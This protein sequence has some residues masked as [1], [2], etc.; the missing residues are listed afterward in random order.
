MAEPESN[1]PKTEEQEP[2]HKKQSFASFVS[3]HKW[4]SFSYLVLFFG[5]ILCLFYPFWGGILVGLILGGYFSQTMLDKAATFKDFIEHEGIFR[6]FVVFAAALALLFEAP[7]LFIGT[8]IGIYV[9]P[10]F[11]DSIDSPFD[12]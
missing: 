10:L 8:L 11:G 6:G 9:R 2:V 7:G 1:E 3:E 4:E 12:E 5:L